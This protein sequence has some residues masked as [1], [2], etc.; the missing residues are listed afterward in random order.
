MSNLFLRIYEHLLPRSEAWKLVID[1][2]LK[3][4]FIGLSETNPAYREFFD[5]VY[6]DLFP[7][8]TR[9]LDEWEA[10][11]GI[12]KKLDV[13]QERRDRLDARWKEEGGQSPQF[14]QDTLQGEGFDVYVHEWWVYDETFISYVVSGN[15]DAR[16]GN[17]NARCGAR[18]DIK[19]FTVDP[20]T[21]LDQNVLVNNTQFAKKKYI[22]N[23]VC[24]NNNARCGNPSALCGA[25]EGFI[26]I[27]VPVTIPDDPDRWVYFWYIGAETFP[28]YADI[29]AERQAE[30]ETLVLRIKPRQTWV[31]LLINFV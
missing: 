4:F 3:D 2:T 19:R 1:K 12:I 8:T 5:L 10:E 23:V 22:A 28:D 30:F 25:N 26:I 16:C 13:E 31:G 6:L 7:Q 27:K 15:N 29:P 17:D 21:L 24:G 9:Q 18:G 20:R 14:I 11:F